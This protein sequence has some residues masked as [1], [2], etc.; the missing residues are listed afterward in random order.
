MAYVLPT[1]A[2]DPS[3][4]GD[5]YHL[6]LGMTTPGQASP[7]RIFG[8]LLAEGTKFEQNTDLNSKSAL[9][10]YSSPH[11]IDRDLVNWP[12]VTDGDFSGGMMQL[13]WIDSSRY[14]DSNL[15]I[16]TPGFLLL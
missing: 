10:Q 15:D 9:T 7:D 4:V 11:L 3:L 12:R 13:N 14:W 6:A 8:Y 1:K 5:S 16:R 2:I